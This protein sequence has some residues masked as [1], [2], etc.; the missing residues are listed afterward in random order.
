MNEGNTF[1]IHLQKTGNETEAQPLL[2]AGALNGGSADLQ[3]ASCCSSIVVNV[4]Y[5]ERV[6]NT[7]NWGSTCFF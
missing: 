4:V 7:S 2:L 5:D 6:P 3:D 1:A